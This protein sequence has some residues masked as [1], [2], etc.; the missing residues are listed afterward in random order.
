MNPEMIVRLTQHS[1]DEKYK[2]NF[3]IKSV[4]QEV[5]KL[6]G[7]TFHQALK[8]GNIF[9]TDY[10]IFDLPQVRVFAES[11]NRYSAAPLA[12]FYNNPNSKKFIPFAIQLYPNFD[13]ES[14]P[15][16]VA[17]GSL[18]WLLAKIWVNSTDGQY[19]EIICHLFECHLVSEIFVVATKRQLGKNHPVYLVRIFAVFL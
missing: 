6:L 17:D 10:S 12:L 3:G 11:F 5:A 1:W 16:F 8:E 14:N 2:N 4:E 15:V 7:V 9:I 13:A 19:M 18:D